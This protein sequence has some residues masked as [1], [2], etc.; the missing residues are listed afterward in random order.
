MGVAHAYYTS[1][2]GFKVADH[3]SFIDL[4]NR[5]RWDYPNDSYSQHP[6]SAN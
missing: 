3:V 1:D 2:V 4:D 5:S 6:H